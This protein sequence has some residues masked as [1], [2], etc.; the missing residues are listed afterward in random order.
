MSLTLSP[1]QFLTPNCRGVAALPL[2]PSLLSC[3]RLLACCLLLQPTSQQTSPDQNSPRGSLLRENKRQ[4]M[5]RTSLDGKCWRP[6]LR[7]NSTSSPGMATLGRTSSNTANLREAS[8]PKNNPWHRER[9]A[10]MANFN[11]SCHDDP[12][13]PRP[14]T[15]RQST[16][17][18]VATLT[19]TTASPSG[20][21]ASLSRASSISSAEALKNL[22]PSSQMSQ[23]RRSRRPSPS[24]SF[25]DF[26]DSPRTESAM[27][28]VLESTDEPTSPLEAHDQ[29]DSEAQSALGSDR[30]L[31]NLD[32]LW[33][34]PVGAD[35]HVRTAQK[36]F[37]VHRDIVTNQ[38]GWFRDHLTPP[39]SV[40]LFPRRH[41]SNIRLSS[42]A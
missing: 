13:L 18:T 5:H 39:N 7:Q 8:P 21:C 28:R 2:S 30:G 9:P 32:G 20:S 23:K 27:G 29:D 11:M 6:P 12:P 16:T 17:G 41:Q 15:P 35:V 25:A 3:H 34:H 26:Q 14:S 4:T 36:S 24:T 33:K 31:T 40:N 42:S 19:N 22:S 38:S 37:F 10:S 1:K